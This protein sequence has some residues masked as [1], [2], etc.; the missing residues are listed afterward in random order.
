MVTISGSP[1]FRFWQESAEFLKRAVQPLSK[2]RG[3]IPLI[4]GDPY[5][6]L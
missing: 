5:F 6:F 3:S 2:I 4:P 1:V